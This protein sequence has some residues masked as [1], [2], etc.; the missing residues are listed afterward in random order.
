MVKTW[1]RP[2]VALLGVGNDNITR[3]AQGAPSETWI[4]AAAGARVA[5]TLRLWLFG[6]L[7]LQASSLS[8]VR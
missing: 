4:Y 2:L 8:A 3:L 7:S 5:S 1:Q 6:T